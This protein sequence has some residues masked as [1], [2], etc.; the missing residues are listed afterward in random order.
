[1][2]LTVTF[3]PSTSVGFPRAVAYARRWAE[4]S[5]LHNGRSEAQFHLGE[6]A[7]PYARAAQLL[8]FVRGWRGTVA[9]IDGEPE[10]LFVVQMMLWCAARWLRSRGD[11]DQ[12]YWTETYVRCRV[13]PLFDPDRA[14]REIAGG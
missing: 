5:E 13:C 9:L 4:C 8:E 7:G 14:A 11:C 3:G 12:R 10:H 6:I 1:M 2:N